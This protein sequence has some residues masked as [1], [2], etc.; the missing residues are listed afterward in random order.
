MKQKLS[1]F[2]F[3]KNCFPK[4]LCDEILAEYKGELFDRDSHENKTTRFVGQLQISDPEI[5]NQ[6]NSYTRKWLEKQI[7]YNVGKLI[8]DYTEYVHP[9]TTM[10]EEDTG[11]SLRQMSVGDYYKEHRDDGKKQSANNVVVTVSICL[12][13]EYEGGDFTFFKETVTKTLKKGDVLMFPS[14]FLFPHGVQEIT[15]GTRYQLLT[16]LR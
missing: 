4:S 1:D 14:N 6:K 16:W 11:Y 13:E 12:N 10:L 8:R 9:F 5:I 3:H 7:F 15:K 2:I